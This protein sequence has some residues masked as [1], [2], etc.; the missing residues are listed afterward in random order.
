MRASA[1]GLDALHCDVFATV[2]TPEIF[3]FFED[4]HLAIITKR[5]ADHQKGTIRGFKMLHPGKQ[6]RMMDMHRPCFLHHQS[7]VK[8][9]S[10][11]LALV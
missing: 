10:G 3:A 6:M 4:Y 11:F 9:F 5:L 1:L 2:L 8:Y 7:A